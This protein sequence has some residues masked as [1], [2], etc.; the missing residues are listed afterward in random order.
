MR[1]DSLP[2]QGTLCVLSLVSNWGNVCRA[3]NGGRDVQ[4]VFNG[5]Y[6]NFVAS[7]RDELFWSWLP[8]PS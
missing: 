4:K 8:D 5:G 3:S 1:F 6:G 7:G 2:I